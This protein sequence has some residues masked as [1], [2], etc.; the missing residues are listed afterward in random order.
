[1]R[2]SFH[3]AIVLSLVLISG[4]A[5]KTEP[6]IDYNPYHNFSAYQTFAFISDHPMIRAE[7]SGS[8]NPLNEGRITNSIE[9]NLANKGFSRVSDPEYADFAI[10]F[11]V[12]A[13]DRIRADSYP[14]TYRAGYGG[15]GRGW[16]GGYHSTQVVNVRNY[17]KGM[18][19][20][21]IFDVREHQ[22]VWH[23]TVSKRI[24]DSMTKDP[25]PVI[26]EVVT[27]ILVSF[28]PI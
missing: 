18:L 7:G 11:T 9:N 16:G 25:G 24:T 27:A 19:S 28:P 22:P 6:I 20:I 3:Y 10:S 17:T 2:N 12:G 23:G 14:T 1:M 4:C 26:H 15:W 21:D 8:G 5:S 13:R